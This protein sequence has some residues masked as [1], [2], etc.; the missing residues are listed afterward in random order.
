MQ[1]TAVKDI[2]IINK[3]KRKRNKSV[4]LVQVKRELVCKNRIGLYTQI[5]E[6]RLTAR[7]SGKISD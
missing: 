3:I 2:Y 5:I 6:C 4:K 7:Y 1:I